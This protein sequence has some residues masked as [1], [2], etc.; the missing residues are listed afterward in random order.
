MDVLES[1]PR[2]LGALLAKQR[3]HGCGQDAKQG[4]G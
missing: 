2:N 1:F 3:A 4:E